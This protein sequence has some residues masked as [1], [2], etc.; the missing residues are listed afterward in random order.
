MI[1]ARIRVSDETGKAIF[2]REFKD[3]A[4]AQTWCTRNI[5]LSTLRGTIEYIGLT[6]YST[7][8]TE[9]FEI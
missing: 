5:G 3:Y 7:M 1:L 2:N 8:Q 4:T 9:E 6:D